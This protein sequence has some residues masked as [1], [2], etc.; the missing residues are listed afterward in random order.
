MTNYKDH[1]KIVDGTI[2][3]I[4]ANIGHS[5]NLKQRGDALKQFALIALNKIGSSEIIIS[6]IK[7]IDF[8][9]KDLPFGGLYNTRDIREENKR[10]A[11]RQG[12]K[13]I[14]G[15]LEQERER[16]V[17]EQQE[18]NETRNLKIQVWTLVFSAIAA[19]GAIISIFF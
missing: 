19:L 4:N 17:K 13:A 16:L 11:Y 12:V 10:N 7:E 9:P 1:I 14:V 2:A 18:V 5:G 15:I 8:P 6:S 3:Q